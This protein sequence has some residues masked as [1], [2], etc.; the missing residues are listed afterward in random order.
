MVNQLKLLLLLQDLIH[1][2]AIVAEALILR[3]LFY[4]TNSSNSCTSVTMRMSKLT[5]KQNYWALEVV[6][7]CCHVVCVCLC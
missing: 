1:S 5:Q 6:V 7:R 4:L 2:L 3:V